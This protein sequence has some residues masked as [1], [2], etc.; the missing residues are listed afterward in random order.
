MECTQMK[1]WIF[2]FDFWGEVLLLMTNGG[3]WHRDYSK[4]D[5]TLTEGFISQVK[6]R[7]WTPQRES[8]AFHRSADITS[9]PPFFF[10]LLSSPLLSTSPE[11]AP[12]P[13]LPLLFLSF[14]W[15]H[16][17]S[18]ASL[19]LSLCQS[20]FSPSVPP[21]LPGSDSGEPISSR[22]CLLFATVNS[23]LR[24]SGLLSSSRVFSFGQVGSFALTLK[25]LWGWLWR[26]GDASVWYKAPGVT[27]VSSTVGLNW[28][29][30]RETGHKTDIDKAKCYK[31][32]NPIPATC[33]ANS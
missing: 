16:L 9:P 30:P 14:S 21:S 13:P 32:T 10:T 19:S 26:G 18:C 33:W 4:E 8:S 6:I 31:G 25:L 22:S 17:S 3:F 20:R 12:A 28:L 5:I 23:A 7:P 1:M 2:H 11:P 27:L 29:W 24:E 15:S